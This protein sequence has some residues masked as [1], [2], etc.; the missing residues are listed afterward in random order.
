[1]KNSSLRF[2]TF[3][4]MFVVSCLVTNSEFDI[5]LTYSEYIWKNVFGVAL[6]VFLNIAWLKGIQILKFCSL[7]LHQIKKIVQ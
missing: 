1:M 7:R 3:F 2:K 4:R 5:I 6:N